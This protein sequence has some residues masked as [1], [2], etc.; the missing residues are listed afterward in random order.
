MYFMIKL[1]TK[2]MRTLD[3][4]ENF[5]SAREAAKMLEVTQARIGFLCRQGRF[6]G[7]EKIGMGWIIPREAVLNHKRLPPGSKPKTLR[8]E[9]IAE[10]RNDVLQQLNKASETHDK[11]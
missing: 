1:I 5:V 8:R 10:I 3:L 6:V 4:H 11:Q 2:E 9:E 7:A